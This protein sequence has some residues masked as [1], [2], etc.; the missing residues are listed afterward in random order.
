MGRYITTIGT[1][2]AVARQISSNYTA[3]VNDRIFADSSSGAFTISLPV[4]ASLLVNDT[5]QIVDVA[6]TFDTNQVTVDPVDSLL[7]GSSDTLTL[8]FPRAIVTLSYSGSTYGWVIIG[9]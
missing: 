7:V 6:G 9:T 8:D 3:E 4:K 5:I 1:A 2:G